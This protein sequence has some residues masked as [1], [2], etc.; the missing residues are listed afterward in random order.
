MP[1]MNIVD[2]FPWN[3]NFETGIPRID[4]QHRK[5]VHLLNVLASHLA[6]QSDAP[7]LNG[8]FQELADYAAHHFATEEAIWHESLAEDEIEA[9]HQHSH[10]NFMVE[11]IKLKGEENNFPL[12][13]VMEDIL[14]FLTHW[15]AFH[16]LEEDM[17]MAKTVQAIQSGMPV[18][19]AK[20]QADKQMSGA[21]KVLINTILDMYDSLSARTI[22]LAREMAERKRAEDKLRLAANVVENTLDAICITD[23]EC[24]VLEA[25]PA[26]YES[27]GYTPEEV[28]GHKIKELKSGLAEEQFNAM[29]MELVDKGEHWSGQ[30]ANRTRGGEIEHEWLT[31]SSVQDEGTVRNYVAVFSNITHLIKQQR[32]L[33]RIAHHDALTGLPNRLLLAD[34]LVQATAHAKRDQEFVAVCFLDLDGFKPVNDLLGH[35][36]GDELL[37]EIARRLQQVV[38]GNDTVARIGGDEFVMLLGEMKQADDYKILLQRV[39][40]EISMPISVA[41]SSAHVTASIG[42]TVY[43]VDEGDVDTL[44]RHADEA[45]Y[46]AKRMGKSQY[47]LY[48][49]QLESVA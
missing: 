17:R 39:L 29:V 45:M 47:C 11:V 26:F 13:K 32:R 20:A 7:T 49:S 41:G 37:K 36:A 4:E 5:L 23:R 15:L 3:E 2:V 16:I 18:D 19:Q 1:H 46:Q 34:R 10:S 9:L 8:V 30:V 43:P 31:M 24:R 21:M 33:E 12:E 6:F 42:V 38:R 35:A 48:D 28:I 27:T 25:N 14:S 22:Q 44:M 40:R